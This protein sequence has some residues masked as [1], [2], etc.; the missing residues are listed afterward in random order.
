MISIAICDDQLI[1]RNQINLY[2]KQIMDELNTPYSLQQFSSG[3]ELLDNYP[4]GLQLIL[5]DIR[6]KTLDGIQ[7]AE[8]IREFDK[9]VLLFFIT[10]LPE[11]AYACYK[12]RAFSFLSK[13]IQYDEFRQ[14]LRAAV[15]HIL[16]HQDNRIA[17]RK[18]HNVYYPSINEILYIESSNH[19]IVYHLSDQDIECYGSL[20]T[21]ERELQD[22]GFF[23]C[24]AAY[25]VNQR[26]IASI[27]GNDITLKNGVVLPISKTKKADFLDK[28]TQFLGGNML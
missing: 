11:H 7:T 15:Q 17:I 28:L 22:K 1:Q 24:H 26:S 2:L 13:P 9:E 16:S 19:N 14:E 21:A 3:E 5:M 10:S 4:S 12:V 23:R 25:L 20:S 27:Q 18:G 8:K 6:M